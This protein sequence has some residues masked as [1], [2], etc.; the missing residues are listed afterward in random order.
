MVDTSS[1][2][3]TS[4]PHQVDPSLTR[5][6]LLGDLPVV[7]LLLQGEI[8]HQP[9]DVAGLPLA[10]AV[11]AAHGLRVV[12]RVPGGVEHHHAVGPDQVHAQA[13]RPA[14]AQP[15]EGSVHSECV[16]VCVSACLCLCVSASMYVSASESVCVCLSE[17]ESE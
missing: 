10:V 6:A 12:A 4:Q 17:C 3:F 2:Q 1:V 5:H 13:A 9:V 14:A 11:H 8:A 15:H 7:D 16:C